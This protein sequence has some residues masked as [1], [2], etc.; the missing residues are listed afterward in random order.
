MAERHGVGDEAA[1]SLGERVVAHVD[2]VREELLAP[3]VGHPDDRGV[4]VEHVDDGARERLERLVERQ[5]LGERARD[6]VERSQTPRGRA[7]GGERG[8]AL[9]SEPGRLLVQLRILDGDRELAGERG[10]QRR[11]VLARGAPHL[12]IRREQPDD[13]TARDERHGE[14]PGHLDDRR[15]PR[16]TEREVEQT[17]RRRGVRGRDSAA[18]RLLEAPV[19]GTKVDGDAVD[20]EDLGDA[21][22]GGLER[23]GDRELGRRLDDHLEQRARAR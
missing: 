3:F 21:L 13:V 23:V 6:L 7:L 18:G 10:E 12:G 20:A 9:V 4:D 1:K 14:R 16:G 22:D 15:E 11:L 19:G 5:A 17:L 2:R 8:L